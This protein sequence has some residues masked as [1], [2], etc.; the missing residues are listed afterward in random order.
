MRKRQRST[1]LN[2]LVENPRKT[3]EVESKSE[4]KTSK[5][6][7]EADA[8]AGKSDKEEKDQKKTEEKVLPVSSSS[9]PKRAKPQN[10]MSDIEKAK[11]KNLKS[12][13]KF[14]VKKEKDEVHIIEY[15]KEKAGTKYLVKWENRHESENSWESRSKIP[16]SVLQVDLV[17]KTVVIALILYFLV[18]RSGPQKTW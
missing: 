18:L 12:D 14:L 9:R 2:N 5:K 8:D 6:I 11:I 4:T 7:K 1:S 16:S 13:L 17:I 15:L 10:S 3:G